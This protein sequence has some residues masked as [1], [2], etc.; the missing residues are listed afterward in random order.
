MLCRESVSPFL[1][2]VLPYIMKLEEFGDFRLVGGTALAFQVGHRRSIDINMFSDRYTKSYNFQELFNILKKKLE[3]IAT[4]HLSDLTLSGMILQCCRKED[5]SECIKMDFWKW[6]NP[7][8]NE[9]VVEENIRIAGLDDLVAMKLEAINDRSNY[10]DYV[11]IAFLTEKYTFS[12][13]ME[14]Y[15]KRTLSRDSTR[16]VSA[17]S[18]PSNLVKD[19]QLDFIKAVTEEELKEKIDYNLFVYTKEQEAKHSRN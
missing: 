4:L 16:I 7:F 1:N 2:E 6:P 10:R 15:T 3:T 9:A 17:L 5:K 14:L 18:N 13:M 19:Q 11:D 12:Q 8:L